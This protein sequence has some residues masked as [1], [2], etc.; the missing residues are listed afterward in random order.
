MKKRMLPLAL[1]LALCL[2][3]TSP[4]GAAG[5]EADG[6]RDSGSAGMA[7]LSQ[8]EIAQLLEDSPLALPDQVFEQGPSC[9]APYAAGQVTTLALQTATNRL[10]ALRRIAGLPAVQ[11]DLTLSGQAQYGAVLIAARGELSH[12]PAQPWDMDG[13]FYQKAYDAA[14]SSNLY[15]GLTLTT[16]VDGFMN[17][18]DA[19]NVGQVGHRRWQLNPEMGK[20]GFG[21]A[22]SNTL[23]RTYVTEKVFDQSGTCTDYDFV[24]WPASGNFPA[25]LFGGDVAWSVSLNPG[26]YSAPQQSELTVTLTRESDGKTWTFQG[27]G[28]AAADRGAYFHVDTSNRG[29]PN[30]IIFRPEGIEHYA[31]VYTVEIGGLRT[32][33]GQA[34]GALAYQVEF[35]DLAS[36]RE[37]APA[38]AGQPEGA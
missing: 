5:G 13:G 29:I 8:K 4:A 30:C 20:V 1:A 33:S 24:S 6:Y 10:N 16:A 35:F 2:G 25:D 3:L 9:R 34:A 32:T 21:Y 23:Y 14:A 18:S 31:G 36:P 19:V 11:L 17:D 38:P 15:A 28:Y 37:E 26:R 22:E 27:S 12:A 7:K